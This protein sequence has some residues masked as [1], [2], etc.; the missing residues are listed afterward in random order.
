MTKSI[1]EHD[2]EKNPWP[3]R[4]KIQYEEL[5]QSWNIYAAIHEM[6]QGW[7][8]LIQL[9]NGFCPFCGMRLM[10][11]GRPIT[12]KDAEDWIPGYYIGEGT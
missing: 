7:F 11:H 8:Y 1:I 4:V 5:T 3:D 12:K 2:C 6:Y 10:L 9:D